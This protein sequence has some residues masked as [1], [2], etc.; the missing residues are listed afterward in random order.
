[1]SNDIKPIL[2]TFLRP[3]SPLIIR[4]VKTTQGNE[5]GTQHSDHEFSNKIEI[6][7]KIRIAIWLQFQIQFG[8]LPNRNCEIFELST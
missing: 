1:M 4:F 6:D 5:N 7:Y 2:L 8:Y 3:N